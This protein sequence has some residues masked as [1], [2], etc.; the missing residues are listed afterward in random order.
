MT[1]TT[2]ILSSLVLALA[3]APAV[4]QMQGSAMKTDGH[5]MK[6][7]KSQMVTMNRCKAMSQTMM[8]KN[9]TCMAMMK[10]HPGMMQSGKM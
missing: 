3:A 9:R 1:R 5:D 2:L 7:S 4:A 10:K 8:A 6:M